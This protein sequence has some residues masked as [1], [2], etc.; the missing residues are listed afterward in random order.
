LSTGHERLPFEAPFEGR[1]AEERLGEVGGGAFQAVE[2][3][4]LKQVGMS[5]PTSGEAS[6]EEFRGAGAGSGIGHG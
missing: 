5:K 6:A 2:V 3:I 4:A 1:L